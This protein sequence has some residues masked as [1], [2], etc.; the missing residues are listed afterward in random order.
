MNSE[1]KTQFYK[2]LKIQDNLSAEFYGSGEITYEN[3]QKYSCNFGA[4][5]LT[6]GDTYFAI[7][8]PRP[9]TH[10]LKEIDRKFNFHGI[11]DSGLIAIIN[12]KDVQFL[13]HGTIVPYVQI[14]LIRRFKI[15]R[16]SKKPIK[17]IKFGLTNFLFTG[18]SFRNTLLLNLCDLP[19]ISIKRLPDYDTIKNQL[20]N[21]SSIAVTSELEI[22][23]DNSQN[24]KE[25]LNISFEIC[26]LLSICRGTKVFWIY[27][28]CYDEFGNIVFQTYCDMTTRSLSELPELITSESFGL[29]STKKFLETAYTTVLQNLLLRRYLQRF[30][31]VFVEARDGKGF[32]ESRGVRIVVVMEMLAKYVLENPYFEISA[33]IL[34]S[35]TCKDTKKAI[36]ESCKSAINAKII[37]SDIKFTDRWNLPNVESM[38]TQNM[39]IERREDLINNLSSLNHTPF[40][41]II[42]RLCE[43]INLEVDEQEIKRFVN[44]RNALI[45]TGNF[46]S[47]PS[48]DRAIFEEYSFLVNFLDRVFLKLFN[49]SGDYNNFRKWGN[50]LRDTI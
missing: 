14:Y 35:S 17:K 47:D 46:Y 3:S 37:D 9:G 43:K 8:S 22:P 25:I 27:Y 41:R 6:N 21:K 18:D 15:E 50:S 12:Q 20:E 38:E 26:H 4:L 49:Y 32:L 1:I 7:D 31:N 30:S 39:V 44:S 29:E 42:V 2:F 10:S 45:H 5:Q 28:R 23:V 34:N 36:L 24:I 11:T 48:V 40:R 33:Y 13:N 16:V 19:A